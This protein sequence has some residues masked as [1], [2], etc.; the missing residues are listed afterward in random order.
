MKT[1]LI[2]ALISSLVFFSPHQVLSS[3]LPYKRELI[4][5]E[6]HLHLVV[7]AANEMSRRNINVEGYKLEIFKKYNDYLVFFK[8]PKLSEFIIGSPE[9]KPT[10]SVLIDENDKVLEFKGIN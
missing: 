2:I 7:I 8:H 4:L 5:D 6:S 10:F 9:G 1:R 3:E